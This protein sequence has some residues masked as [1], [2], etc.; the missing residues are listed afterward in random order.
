MVI[1]ISDYTYADDTQLY[2]NCSAI[3]GPTTAA[4]L[5]WHNDDIDCWMLS[6]C[7]KLK[8]NKTQFL[9]LGPPLQL[10]KVTNV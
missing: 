3:D 6:Y 9:W 10:N 5:L 1:G 7:L 8:S 2:T 4:Q